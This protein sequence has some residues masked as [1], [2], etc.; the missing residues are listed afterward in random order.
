MGG[1][2]R[3]A[4]DA[5]S[6]NDLPWPAPGGSLSR[7]LYVAYVDQPDLAGPDRKALE[8]NLALARSLGAKVEA[9]DG[10]NT[11]QILLRFARAHGITQIFVGHSQRTS[12]WNRILGNPVERLIMESEG[13]DVRVFPN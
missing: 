4:G 2:L 1:H 13:I 5:S 9:L 6:C 11:V 7:G 3:P 8:D 10:E 12:W